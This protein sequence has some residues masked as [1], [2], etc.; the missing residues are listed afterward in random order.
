MRMRFLGGAASLLILANGCASVPLPSDAG[1]A[2]GPLRNIQLYTKWPKGE[3][4]YPTHVRERF[5]ASDGEIWIAPHWIL[6]GPGEHVSKIVLRTPS[7]KVHRESEYRFR[8]EAG[9][10]IT[11]QGIELPRGEAAKPLGGRWEVDVALDG[12]SVGRRAFTFD[13]SSIRLRT[14]ARVSVLR[15]KHDIDALS[16]SSG[17]WFWRDR[18]GTLE[19]AVSALSVLG[20]VLRDELARR[21]PHVDG[22]LTSAEGSG[23]TVILT[24]TLLLSPNA[25]VNPQLV[26]EMVHVPTKTTGKFRAETAAGQERFGRGGWSDFGLAA[27]DLAFQT[28]SSPEVLNFLMRTTGAVSE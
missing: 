9:S 27:V 10:W 21:F 1:G 26:L 15:G 19:H 8:A 5:F 20:V 28:A 4:H 11:G 25:D 18:Q 16:A 23:A 7:G 13:P 14:D 3:E 17:D 6:P 2:S 12:R 22:P 24:P